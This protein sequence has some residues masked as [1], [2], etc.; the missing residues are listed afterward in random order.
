MSEKNLEVGDLVR[1]SAKGWDG[2]AG[3]VSKPISEESPGH[4]LVH[5]DGCILGVQATINDVAP[6][7]KG[8]E[9]FAQ[10]AYNLIKLGSHVTEKR[11]LQF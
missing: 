8:S 9:G 3:I 2:L 10:I 1:L 7:D 4:V 5:K 11:L 6:A